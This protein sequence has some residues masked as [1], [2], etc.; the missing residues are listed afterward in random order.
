MLGAGA[1]SRVF[2][3]IDFGTLKVLALKIIDIK[4]VSQNITNLYRTEIEVLKEFTNDPHVIQLFEFEFIENAEI[5]LIFELGTSNFVEY[6]KFAHDNQY[7]PIGFAK[8]RW[9]EVLNIKLKEY[10]VN[11]NVRWC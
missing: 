10:S 2:K 6:L 7:N 1:S 9:K 5:K 4:G 11:R 8:F 3:V